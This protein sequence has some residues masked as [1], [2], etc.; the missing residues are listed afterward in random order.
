MAANRKQRQVNNSRERVRIGR[1]PR[2]LIIVQNLPVPADRRVWREAKALRAAGMEVTVISPM[3][4]G[5]RVSSVLDGVHLLKYPPAPT[6]HGVL[7]Y[8]FEFTYCWMMTAFLTVSVL[9]G[10]GFDLLQACNPPDTYFALA[11]PLKLLGKRFVFD[12]HDLSP[13]VYQTRFGR[14]SGILLRILLGMER[15]T[16]ALADHVISTNES[17]RR[18]ALHRGRLASHEVT[19]V[20]NGPDPTTMRRGEPQPSLR[21]GREHLCCYLGVMGPQDGVETVLRVTAILV[22]QWERSVHVALLGSGDSLDGLRALAT[23]LALDDHITFTG[24]AEDHTITDYLSTAD[25]GLCP[26]PKTPFNDVST[27]NKTLEYMAYSLPMVSFDLKETRISAGDASLYIASDSDEDF[28]SAVAE[29]L[30]D[31]PR[32]VEMGAIGRARVEQSLGW[33]TQESRYVATIRRLAVT[34]QQPR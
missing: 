10:R 30:D 19:V 3:T 6:T 13:E 1:P 5:D 9:A 18:V 24:W 27:M 14:E 15:A 21:M 8:A 28:A 7:S 2:V 16:Y 34:N 26:D 11:A 12:Q 25:V 23:Q 31:P 32:R 20:R 4:E 22:H 29:L 17:Y 33:Q